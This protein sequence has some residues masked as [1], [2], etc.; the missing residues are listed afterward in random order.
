MHSDVKIKK[1]LSP[2]TF[3]SAFFRLFSFMY[4]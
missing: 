2:G 1:I 4:N 3:P